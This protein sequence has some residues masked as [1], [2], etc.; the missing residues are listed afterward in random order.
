M[1]EIRRR[2]AELAT[3]MAWTIPWEVVR[4]EA[5]PDTLSTLTKR[6]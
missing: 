2:S 5:I 3:G 6:T 4:G 1:A